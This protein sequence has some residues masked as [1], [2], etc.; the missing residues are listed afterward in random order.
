[1]PPGVHTQVFLITVTIEVI[2][3]AWYLT[4]RGEHTTLHT[5]MSNTHHYIETSE[6][7]YKHNIVFVTPHTHD[8]WS[9][10]KECSGDEVLT[11]RQSMHYCSVR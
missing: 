1:M 2:F 6:T 11:K 5:I 4:G 8:M 10:Q 7:M 3:T 9:A